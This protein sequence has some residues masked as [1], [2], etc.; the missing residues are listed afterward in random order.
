M[1]CKQCNCETKDRAGKL[2]CSRDCKLKYKYHNNK[3]FKQRKI[4]GVYTRRKN[5]D[6]LVSKLK[7]ISKMEIIKNEELL[8]QEDKIKD[9]FD[10]FISETRRASN[11]KDKWFVFD[12]Q[13]ETAKTIIYN[14][15]IRE[16][17]W[18]LLFAEMQSGKSG[19]F[20]SVPFIISRNQALINTLG[21]EMTDN[22][23]NVYLLTGMN[24][25]ELIDQFETDISNFTGMD[26][27]KNILHNSE[28]NKFLSKPKND[29]LLDDVH[30][31]NK[32][33]KNSLILIDESHYGSDKN[34]VLNKF[35]TKILEINPNG[36]NAELVKNN[37]YVVSVSAT[38][39]AEFVSANISEFKKKIVPL[40]NSDTYCGI[41]DMF[42]KGKIHKSYDLKDNKSID[43]FLDR[44][45][46]I[47]NIGY[48]IVRCT[49]KQQNSIKNRIGE[50][51]LDYT[52]I[53]YDQ[54]EKS[55]IL[56][57]MG[58]NDILQQ[59]P[60][61]K[62]IIF[63]K[64]LLR[65]GKRVDTRNV[66]MMH[67][68]ANSNVD[69]T[70]QSL[71]GRC[72]GY[73]KNTNIEIYCDRESAEKYKKW[74]DSDYDLELVPDKSRNIITNGRGKYHLEKVEILKYDLSNKLKSLYDKKTR[75]KKERS[76]IILE[77]IDQKYQNLSDCFIGS[78]YDKSAESVLK[79]YNGKD[80]YLCLGDMDKE[81]N[82]D[83]NP[84]GKYVITSC[85]DQKA[86]I[87]TIEFSIGIIRE[88]EILTNEKSMY[89][90]S[91]II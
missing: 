27:K 68:T 83:S 44:V 9:M 33:K 20:F 18:C 10:S 32:M 45:D 43:M 53:N 36:D 5:A 84:L 70:V 59:I 11:V 7:L 30:I 49:S 75:N 56:N 13:I 50:R 85:I 3:E 74:V 16:N 78:L 62:T 1:N 66:L 54:Y 26:I 41:V 28:M 89:H 40:K 35:L 73:G 4:D 39:M 69:T 65:A 82:K 12:N 72:C 24:E 51:G 90:E 42:N 46:E 58:I 77:H 14:F 63:L 37:I 86:S 61:K 67:D 22:D 71:L 2:F 91:N 25:K 31:I 19:T 47:S 8:I 38:P 79:A 76:I 81:F 21:I 55:R 48:I 6:E 17:R 60:K 52:I 57:N 88:Q 80:G 29:W 64:G 87:P 34:Q 23:I 15:Y